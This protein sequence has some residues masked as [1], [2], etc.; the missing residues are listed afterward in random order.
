MFGR[1]SQLWNRTGLSQLQHIRTIN[2]E[3]REILNCIFD[4]ATFRSQIMVWSF[5]QPQRTA[6]TYFLTKHQEPPPTQKKIPLTMNHSLKSQLD[7]NTKHTLVR[8]QHCLSLGRGLRTAATPI[9]TMYNL[10][11]LLCDFAPP[12]PHTS[13][14]ARTSG[15]AR[16]TTPLCPLGCA[17]PGSGTTPGFCT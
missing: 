2:A 6:H 8:G 12:G 5:A 4:T 16:R 3:H 7:I 9:F 14:C 13:S 10:A 1:F 15:C 17:T 11:T